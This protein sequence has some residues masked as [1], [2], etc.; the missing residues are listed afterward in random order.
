[1]YGFLKS[2]VKNLVYYIPHLVENNTSKGINEYEFE[3]LVQHK[4]TTHGTS[5]HK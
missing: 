5:I 1:M 4:I 2:L 3:N